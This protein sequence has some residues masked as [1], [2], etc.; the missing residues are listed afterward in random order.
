M[1]RELLMDRVGKVD[2]LICLL[3]DTID[4]GVL[5]RRYSLRVHLRRLG[6]LQQRRRR[7]YAQ[8]RGIMVTNTPDVLTEAT[9]NLTWALILGVD[10]A[11]RRRRS[12][13]PPRRLDRLPLRLPARQRSRRQAARHHRHGPHRPG[14]GA[15]RAWPSAWTSPTCRARARTGGT[16][17]CAVRDGLRARA[18]AVRRAARDVGR[19][20]RCTAPLTAGD[21]SSHRRRRRSRG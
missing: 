4:R 19:R 20:R 5:E 16:S 2:A 6:R 14:G 12:A 7:R 8:A 15:P 13:D 10:A 11:H 3:T 1:P 17:I 21:A 9:A 18:A